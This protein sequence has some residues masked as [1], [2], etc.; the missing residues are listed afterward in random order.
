MRVNV[1]Y[2]IELK[3]VPNK[4][5]ELLSEAYPSLAKLL[6]QIQVV[7]TSL[8]AGHFS[9]KD[10][11]EKIDNIRRELANID[12]KMMDCTEILHGYQSA[13][14]Q[15]REQKTRRTND[16]TRSEEVENG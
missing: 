2:S 4:V 14:V 10:E 13:L 7:E 5:S 16:E 8:I 3:E 15:L 12:F 1:T 11:L 6:D 9:I